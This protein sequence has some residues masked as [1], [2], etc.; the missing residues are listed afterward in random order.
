MSA[1]LT[2]P[3]GRGPSPGRRRGPRG[4]GGSPR[5]SG[6]TPSP[7]GRAAI[8]SLGKVRVPRP[9]WRGGV[10]R[11][12]PEVGSLPLPKRA[13]VP[14]DNARRGSSPSSEERKSRKK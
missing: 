5:D 3:G 6:T 14:R 4:R 12:P 8:A 13:R 1:A 2:R 9:S 7:P 10:A 11:P